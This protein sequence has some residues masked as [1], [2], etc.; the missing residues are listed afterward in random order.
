MV[1]QND[2]TKGGESQESKVTGETL[3]DEAVEAVTKSNQWWVDRILP[4]IKSI[5]KH[6]S[7]FTTDTVWVHAKKRGLPKPSKDPRAMGG[8]MTAARKNKWCRA[9]DC[10]KKSTRPACHCRPVRI[11]ESLL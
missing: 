2:H 9:T 7:S 3:R 5:C 4:I 8:A 1:K 10:T 6:Y 11:W